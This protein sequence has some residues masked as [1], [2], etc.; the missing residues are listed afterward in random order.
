MKTREKNI[1]LRAAYATSIIYILAQ[2][3]SILC[4]LSRIPLNPSLAYNQMCFLTAHNAFSSKHEGW[5]LYNQQI[6]NIGE[7]LEAG[8]RGFM[9]DVYLAKDGNTVLLCHNACGI[10]SA[11]QRSISEALKNLFSKKQSV[12]HLTEYLM[13]FGTW[14]KKN[15]TQIITIFFENY[16][17]NDILS[18]TIASVPSFAS[19]VLTPRDWNL[20]EKNYAWPLIGEM[21]AQNK[22]IVIF[23]ENKSNTPIKPEYPF[24]SQRECVKESN[25]GTF[26]IEK[27]AE[28]RRES[29]LH[30]AF[31]RTLTLLNYFGTV[32]FNS[33]SSRYNRSERVWLAVQEWML[34]Q[35][36]IPNFIAFDFIKKPEEWTAIW[37]VIEKVNKLHLLSSQPTKRI[38]SSFRD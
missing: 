12:Y 26:A 33:R 31:T 20:A 3:F 34:K 7:Q 16:V 21:Q 23:N 32:V 35:G 4:D 22:R 17:N 11:L 18:K 36:T 6:L 24:F 9:L 30:Q 8:V 13:L 10:T 28:Q 1:F 38:D 29:L 15:P 25:F 37:E 14:L 2:Q 27:I 5:K 19:L